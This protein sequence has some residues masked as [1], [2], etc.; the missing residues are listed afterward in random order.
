[1]G[2]GVIIFSLALRDGA[3]KLQWRKKENNGS[4]K[5]EGGRKG[6]SKLGIEVGIAGHERAEVVRGGI[7]GRDETTKRLKRR[8]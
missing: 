1:M 4:R 3:G 2:E 8:N 5:E 7:R 6:G